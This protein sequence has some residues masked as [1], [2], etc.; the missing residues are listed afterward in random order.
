ME[1]WI[2]TPFDILSFGPRVSVGLLLSMPEKLQTLWVGVR[3]WCLRV[4]GGWGEMGHG[5]RVHG[6]TPPAPPAWGPRI[7]QACVVVHACIFPPPPQRLNPTW[8]ARACA[9]A[10]KATSKRRWSCCRTLGR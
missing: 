10:A 6:H 7:A 5:I 3:A 4:C 9:T 2:K 8:P 1:K